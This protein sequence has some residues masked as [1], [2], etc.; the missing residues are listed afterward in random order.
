MSGTAESAGSRRWIL[1]GLMATMMLAAMDSTIVSTAI[2]QIVGDLGD[3]SLFAWV[4]SI[5][6]LAQT[7]TIPVYGK[8]ADQFGR[9]PVLIVGTLV[10]LAGSAASAGAWSMLSLIVFRA[11]QGLGAGS[12]MATVNTLAGDLFSIRERARVQGWLSSMWGLSAIIGPALGGAFAEYASWRWIFLVNLPVGAVSLV[13]IGRNLHESF[14]R[15]R[16]RVDFSGAALVL[17]T[18][19]MLVLGLLQ[20]GEQWPWLSLPS[21]IVFAFVLVFAALT[22]AVERRAAEPILPAW[23]WRRRV[24]AGSNLAMVGMGIVMMGPIAYLPTFAQSVYGLGAI[25]AGFLLAAMSVGW[26]IASALSGRIYLRLGFR[27]SALGGGVLMVLAAVGFLAL[28]DPGPV[29]AVVLDQVVL[30]AGFGLLSTPLL[31]GVQS[32]VGWEERGVVT[33]TN[34][35]ARYLGQSLGAAIFGAIFNAALASQLAAA[36]AAL[37]S[38]LP[39][40]VNE[41][42]HALHDPALGAAARGFLRHAIYVATHHIYWGIALLSILTLACVL[43]APGRFPLVGGDGGPRR[44][45]NGNT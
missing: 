21:G 23:L 41:V 28:P 39:Q 35:F 44:S 9:K 7:V 19:G 17:A 34:M 38:R 32:V 43:V 16:H 30:G 27:D 26:P 42:I 13:L 3:F 40:Q 4:F 33:G 31:V 25:A 36:P 5:Y 6:V 18:V 14:A 15:S 11:F 2:P 8:L 24:L 12:I 45:A 10:F 37:R 22:I 20:G 1:A 29:W